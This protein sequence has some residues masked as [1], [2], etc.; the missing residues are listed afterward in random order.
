MPK[1]IIVLGLGKTGLSCVRYLVK[2]GYDPVAIDS[3]ERP[4]A[5]SELQTEFPDIPVYLGGF[6]E[7]IIDQADEIIISP[8][9]SLREL[10][11]A[12]Q[13]KKGKPVL[14]DIELFAR[15]AKAPVV[16][17][18]G[19]N[20]KST[21]T[22]LVGE[23]AK[24]SGLNARVGGNLG[25]P[26]L[27]L[28]EDAEPDLYVLE[29]SSFQLETACS[30]RTETAVVLNISPDH[31]DR[32][33]SIAEYSAAK[34]RIYNNCKRPIF[35]RK[36][37][38]SEAG[39]S[40]RAIHELHLQECSFGLDEPKPGQFGVRN[41][42][43][44][45][46]DCNLLPI[47]EMRIKGAHQVAN[48]LAAL[49]LG[50]AVNLPMPAMLET[51]RNFEGLPHRCHWVANINGANWYNDSKGTNVGAACAAITG[52]G[53]SIAGKIVLIAGGQGKG[54]DFSKIFAP[55]RLHTRAVI[56][57]GEDALKIKTALQ[58]ASKILLAES[59]TEAVDVA[60]RQAGQGDAVLLS[61]AC[62]SFDMFDNFEHRGEVFMQLVNEKY[63]KN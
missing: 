62:A 26:A 24:A 61:P 19:S 25:M 37:V 48:A 10:A 28:L 12:K 49:A 21:V 47:D 20:G 5:L 1:K 29:L 51:L 8:G 22:A 17:I 34:M 18:T 41:G 50:K 53:E 16:A 31:M 27:D 60:Y 38:L 56:L 54:A 39:F 32:Y 46:G 59:M 43:L 7:K 23:M 44:A 35:N 33:A 52:I 2:C 14:G 58:G 4:P 45:Y 11:V 9:I 63:G 30:L 13:I 42:F 57:I 36:I 15:V 6:D 3:R 55:V 40:A